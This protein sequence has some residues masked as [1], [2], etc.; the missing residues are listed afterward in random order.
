MVWSRFH[1]IF[2]R[3]HNFAAKP[4]YDKPQTTDPLFSCK[5]EF[6][7]LFGLVSPKIRKSRFSAS[8]NF[9]E[10]QSGNCLLVVCLHSC[11]LSR[12]YIYIYIYTR[13]SVY[14]YICTYRER[15]GIFAFNH[16]DGMSGNTDC[17][18]LIVMG[19]MVSNDS[20]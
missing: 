19:L 7:P 10:I 9:W 13:T 2:K 4:N 6:E 1:Q 11:T 15:Y 8:C 20:P 14:I 12:I 3:F 5:Y 17:C 16:G 18:S